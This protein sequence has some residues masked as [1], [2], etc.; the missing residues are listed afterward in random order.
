KVKDNIDNGQ[1]RAVQLAGACALDQAEELI[2]PLNAVYQR[3]RDLVVTTLNGLG[4]SLTPPKGTL[5]LWAP[6]PEGFGGDSLKFAA[7][8][9]ETAGVAVTPGIG[10]G[11]HGEGYFRISLTYPDAVLVTAMERLAAA[12]QPPA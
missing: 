5:Y 10:Y 3:R 9:L 6:V 12:L 2:P 11:E 8:L 7:H 1:L 4:W